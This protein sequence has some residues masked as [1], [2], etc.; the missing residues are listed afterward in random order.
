VSQGSPA[1]HQDLLRLLAAPVPAPRRSGRPFL[2]TSHGIRVCVAALDALQV[3]GIGVLVEHLIGTGHPPAQAAAM[4]VM[5]ALLAGVTRR[6]LR[7]GTSPRP[8][9]AR[10]VS[11]RA[12]TAV[13][14]ALCGV[15]ACFWIANPPEPPEA[16]DAVR[17]LLA[18]GF[19]SA[20]LAYGIRHAASYLAGRMG[21]M[22][23][24]LALVGSDE[25]RH[26]MAAAL[27]AGSEPPAW[28][29]AASLDN[30]E[31]GLDQLADLAQQGAIDVVAVVIGGPDSA[32][33]AAMV[34]SRLADQ[35]VRVCLA[36]EL[37]PAVSGL[38]PAAQSGGMTL[39]DLH[40]YPHRGW[41]G[42]AKRVADLVLASAALVVLSPLFLA[43]AAAIRLESPGNPFFGQWRFGQGSRPIKVW[44]FRS[45][46][47][48]KGDPTGGQRTLARDPRV[49]RVGRFLRRSSIDELPQLINVVRGEMSLVGPRPHPLHMRI[50]GAYY[51]EAVEN[52]R[53][54]HLVKPGLTGWA[55]I[56]GSRGEVDTI[57]K[58]RRRVE[59]DRWYLENWSLGLDARIVLRT[60][61]G[62]FRT[63]AD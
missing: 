19:I 8:D 22:A 25:A 18:W 33:R 36:L 58:A 60:A 24:A 15:L 20:G 56:N 51:F 32:L 3:I 1:A 27:T 28:R 55:Q 16:V 29:L 48:A 10:S 13:M 38:R 31:A 49:T 41:P 11:A 14:I 62:G 40:S 53:I 21:Q 35:P 59:L 46:N 23:P 54:R 34:C 12:A 39:F 45:M 6:A 42:T 5:A 43:V 63:S 7:V 30:S 37:L 50:D 9:S 2:G 61:L 52:Y 17:W 26:L 4:G 47:A 44:K 57:A